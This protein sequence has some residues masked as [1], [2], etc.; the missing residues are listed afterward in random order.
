VVVLDLDLGT[1]IAAFPVVA[2]IAVA[3]LDPEIQVVEILI[4]AAF[5][6]VVGKS[7]EEPVG[8]W[9][10][11]VEELKFDKPLKFPQDIVFFSDEKLDWT[12]PVD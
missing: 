6:I 7:P 5:L 12:P 2:V 9:M 8:Y 11:M 3:F 10:E 4:V 1:L